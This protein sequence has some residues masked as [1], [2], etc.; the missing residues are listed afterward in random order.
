M[1]VEK[2]LSSVKAR[3]ILLH[4]GFLLLVA[5]S[6]IATVVGLQTTAKDASIINLAGRQR[7]LLQAITRH[8]LEVEKHPD[9]R[10]PRDALAGAADTFDAT[11]NALTNGGLAP[12]VA[13]RTVSLP[14][15][16]DP[17]V[18]ARLEQVRQRWT[19]LRSEVETAR[20][21]SEDDPALSLAVTAIEQQS[22]P[23]VAAMDGAVQAFEQM[24]TAKVR[25]LRTIQ[26]LL[27]AGAVF[28]V[29]LGYGFTSRSV[30]H[31]LQRL[32]QVAR[33][34]GAGNLTKPVPHLGRD[35]VAQLAQSLETM[36]EQ[37]HGAR[38]DLE[39]RVA[40]RTRE[41]AALY[42]VSRE[43]SSH[44]DI[45]HVL[46]S[47]TDKA[48]ELLGG[49]VAAL[50]LLD[51]AGHVLDL[52]AVSGPQETLRETWVSAQHLPA[53]RVLSEDRA[54]ACGTDDC[55]G[56]C[57]I[58]AAPFRL[59]HLAASL[60]ARDRV[61][62]ALCIGSARAGAF[63][64]EA[65][66]LLTKLAN[67]A[68]IALENAHLY[69]QAERVATLEERQRIAAEM[70]DGLT[71]T[72]SYL[73]LQV[74]LVADR[75][76]AKGDTEILNS[77][78]T[79]LSASLEHIRET[80]A[81]AVDEVRA[82]IAGLSTFSPP[83]QT[84]P[85]LLG[86]VVQEVAGGQT[87]GLTVTAPSVEDLEVAPDVA[88]QIRRIVQEALT[89]ACRHAEANHIQVRL[90]ELDGEAVIVVEDD[91]RGFEPGQG[92]ADGRRHFGL[93]TMRARAARIGGRLTVESAP[94]HGTRVVLW[95]PLGSSD[96][97]ATDGEADS[98]IGG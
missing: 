14:P 50:C 37:L 91:G 54:L 30:I 38:E 53:T 89:N 2:M 85:K 21:A 68:A 95:W 45:D 67:A 5:G 62:G 34:I 44:L 6:V 32:Q 64:G 36:R 82:N 92:P 80:L 93:S 3:L 71:Q 70:H 39:A 57:G 10:L 43:I 98:S 26:G 96:D 49:E 9:E 88:E 33:D 58:I 46:R 11:L 63:S 84:L 90:E 29:L 56:S 1:N 23:L 60:R 86:G 65:A 94:G 76:A 52:Q 15:V 7:M 79:E 13:D 17:A 25:R 59:S 77:T 42:E 35:E 97:G 55:M 19:R 22:L 28:L 78:S 81:Q 69:E 4:L 61:I 74:D 24:A 51:E 83:P 72:L 20:T 18:W 87:A 12:Y 40:Q 75:I 48:R 73:H 47:V 27:L 16:R 31:P 66:N 41:L 8:A